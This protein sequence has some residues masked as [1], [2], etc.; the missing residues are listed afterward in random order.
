MNDHSELN[1]YFEA[2][3]AQVNDSFG[4]KHIDKETSNATIQAINEQW[5][6]ILEKIGQLESECIQNNILNQT[7]TIMFLK[8]GDGLLDDKLLIMNMPKTKFDALIK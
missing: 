4:Q 8:T 3:K 1:S 6:D 2:L 5:Q 7:L